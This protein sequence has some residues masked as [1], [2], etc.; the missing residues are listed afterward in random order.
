M[1]VQE[2]SQLYHLNREVEMDQRRLEELE[3]QLGPHSPAI[4]GM[5][6]GS[7]ATD[8]AVERL[9]A[10]IVDLQAIIASKQI[11]CIHERARLERW[12]ES[13]ADSETRMM[14]TFRFVNGLPWNQV[15]AHMGEGY[16]G[17]SI[18]VKCYRYLKSTNKEKEAEK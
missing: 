18:R 12:I 17:E 3:G 5:P 6:K 13:I 7:P 10:E 9:M 2:L 4:T 14:F 15:A 8:S 16:M 1:T 11:Q